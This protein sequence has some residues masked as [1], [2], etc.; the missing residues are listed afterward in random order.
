MRSRDQHLRKMKQRILRIEAGGAP[1]LHLRRQ[2]N[3]N[4]VARRK[5]HH[6]QLAGGAIDSNQVSSALRNIFT[7]IDSRLRKVEEHVSRVEEGLTDVQD[8]K[9]LDLGTCTIQTGSTMQPGKRAQRFT[10]F[11]PSTGELI[12]HIESTKSENNKNIYKRIPV[13]CIE[14]DNNTKRD[15]I[16]YMT[17]NGEKRNLKLV[18]SEQGFE[19]HKISSMKT[20]CLQAKI[21]R[22]SQPYVENK[23]SAQSAAKKS[24]AKKS[25]FSPE[26]PETKVKSKEDIKNMLSELFAQNRKNQ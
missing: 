23:T 12:R 5:Q 19:E 9:L 25:A 26:T 13:W 21:Q 22:L 15:V 3:T 11:N 10:Q 6:Q 7:E 8:L 2:Y 1:Q 17:C 24:V 14:E 16:V 20:N 4:L 18:E